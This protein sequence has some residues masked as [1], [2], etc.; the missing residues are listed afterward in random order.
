MHKE[1]D[2]DGDGQVSLEEMSLGVFRF[3][4]DGALVFCGFA[5][6]GLARSWTLAEESVPEGTCQQGARRSG[7][8]W[9]RK[10]HF[11]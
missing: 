9:G 11:R 6:C 5:F 3:F 4:Q 7:Q 8:G 1:M 2:K 10:D